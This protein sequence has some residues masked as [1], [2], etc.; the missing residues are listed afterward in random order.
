MDY[1]E[2]INIYVP[3]NVGIVLQDD[4]MRFEIFRKDKRTINKNRYLSLLIKG[5]Y[6]SYVTEYSKKLENLK[7]T[8]KQYIDDPAI[9]DKAALTIINQI[10]LPEVPKRKG[11]NPIK[12]SLKPTAAT[13]DTIH[14]I[15]DKMSSNDYISQY[16]C[17]MFISYCEKPLYERERIICRE[18]YNKL[19]TACFSHHPISFS[20]IW[21]PDIIHEVIPYSISV[22]KDEMF[23]YLLCQEKNNKNGALEA[24]TYRLN[25][26]TGIHYS[27]STLSLSADVK[28][29]LDIMKKRGAQYPVNDNQEICVKLSDNGLISYNRIYQGRP[30]ADRVEHR[31]DGHYYYFQ[32]SKEQAFLY[33]KKFEGGTAEV[34]Y[35]ESLRSRLIDFHT[36]VLETYG[37][38]V[39]INRPLHRE[40]D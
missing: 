37:L 18:T 3:E 15:T 27:I 30:T 28:N 5:Y 24:R 2:K 31:S 7:K 9:C 17:R 6:D 13:E 22:G 19:Q 11:K 35:P 1:R 4:A 34:L 36:S 29:Y 21:S 40:T 16:F 38:N 14:E 33:F 10:V 20:T 39:D 23:N 12:L 32:C 8:L 25:R 26:V